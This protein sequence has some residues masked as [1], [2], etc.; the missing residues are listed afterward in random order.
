VPPTGYGGIETIVD[1]LARGFK[2][3]GHDVVMAAAGGSTCP[4]TLVETFPSPPKEMGS[5]AVE[6]RHTALAYEALAGCHII[7]DHTIMGPTVGIAANRAPIVATI[8]SD[9]S[10]PYASIYENAVADGVQHIFISGAQRRSAKFSTTGPVIHHGLDV[11]RYPFGSASSSYFLFLGRMHPDK[12]LHDAIAAARRAEVPLL[13]AA[14]MRDPHEHEYFNL[15][16][17]PHLGSGIEY[18]GEASQQR[19]IKLLQHARALLFPVQWAEPFGLVMIEALACG[20]PV[21]AYPN[22][23]VPEVIEHGVTGFLAQDIDEMANAIG[24]S[25]GLDRAACRASVERR[26]SAD[27]MVDEHLRYFS[28]LVATAS[29][30]E[31]RHD[32]PMASR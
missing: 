4:V 13:I 3:R 27:K 8:H 16:V 29:I 1:S 12:G 32:R 9:M 11:E 15:R 23:A 7:H 31:H 25:G 28:T 20:T 24:L 10:P 2:A 14:K 21:L 30:T 18:I 5:V 19:K 22:G 17:K 26:F 6:L